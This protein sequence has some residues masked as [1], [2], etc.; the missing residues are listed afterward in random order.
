MYSFAGG[1]TNAANPYCTPVVDGN[2]I[3]GTTRL[4][5]TN[6]VG[7]IFKLNTDGSGFEILHHFLPATGSEPS[8]DLTLT[9][10]TL[11]GFTLKGGANNAGAIFALNVGE[12]GYAFQGVGLGRVHRGGV[13]NGALASVTQ[14]TWINLNQPDMPY[15]LDTEAALHPCD[16]VVAAWLAMTV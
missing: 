6:N 13:N 12:P 14:P 10:N 3:Y 1:T 8:G 7:T 4:G 2:V 9:N 16:R 11:Y 5:G 15:T